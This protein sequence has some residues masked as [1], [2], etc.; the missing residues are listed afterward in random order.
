MLE[1]G[2]K[3]VAVSRITASIR[4]KE[5]GYRRNAIGRVLVNANANAKNKLKVIRIIFCSCSLV[6]L[7]EVFGSDSA[8]CGLFIGVQR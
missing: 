6:K 2:G 7:M 3:L 4:R 8:D 1:S 5:N